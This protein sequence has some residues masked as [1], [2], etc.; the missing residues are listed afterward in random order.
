MLINKTAIAA[1]VIATLGTVGAVSSASAASLLADGNYQM[2]ILNNPGT[3]SAVQPGADG[4]WNST[5][6]FGGKKPN[7]AS[8]GMFN[9]GPTVVNGV[10]TGV[11]DAY[12]GVLN[13]T[14]TGGNFTV[15]KFQVDPI[16]GT[17]GGT[18]AQYANSLVGMNGTVGATGAISF[19]P[20]GRLGAVSGFPTLVNERWNVDNFG[21]ANLSNTAYQKFSTGSAST[22]NSTQT[23]NTVINGAAATSIGDV[24]GDGLTDYK[25]VLVSG[26]QVGSDW[27][28]FY[29]ASYLETWSVRLVS[30][31]AVTATPIPAAAWLFGSGLVGLVGVAR[32]KKA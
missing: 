16:F 28:G 22:V 12:A 30:Q 19:D 21:A 3:A 9:S 7:V 26:G 11:N 23:G 17:A 6:T 27:A 24:N 14:V 18:F 10:T 4:A 2:Q 25:A 13:I 8:Q 29:G 1:A 15:T 5:F 20:T 31:A 32:R